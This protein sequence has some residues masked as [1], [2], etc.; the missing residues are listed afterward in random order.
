MNNTPNR[1]DPLI[2]ARRRYEEVLKKLKRKRGTGGE[3]SDE[4][5]EEK[6]KE[7]LARVKSPVNQKNQTSPVQNKTV[8]DN[9][10]A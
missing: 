10:R 5:K 4:E 1:A 3:A 8:G 2:D 7:K 6:N 9:E